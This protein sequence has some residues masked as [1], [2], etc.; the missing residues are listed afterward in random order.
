M[1]EWKI[2]FEGPNDT[3]FTGGVF[4]AKMKFPENYPEGP[5]DLLIE[6]EFWHPNVYEDGK[7]CISI[8]HTPGEDPLNDG[9]TEMMRWL[10]THSFSTIFNSFLSILDDP[11]GAPANVDA[12]AQYNRDRP[13][14]TKKVQH[15]AAK[16]R[17]KCPAEL[18]KKIPHPHDPKD[19]SYAARVRSER[20]AAGI[21]D[22]PN[23]ADIE[24]DFSGGFDPT[25]EDFGDMDFDYGEDADDYAEDEEEDY[26]LDDDDE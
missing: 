18:L 15:L 4:E 17:E 8:L 24:V 19:P 23:L 16:S 3:A 26:D 11:G 6:S 2:W 12:N 9:E 5:P 7:L 22:E 25:G 1:F 21:M 10:P 20:E 14:Y 13:A